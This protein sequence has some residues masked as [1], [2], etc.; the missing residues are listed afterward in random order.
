MSAAKQWSRTH[1]VYDVLMNIEK[2][3]FTTKDIAEHLPHLS[4][5]Q[6]TGAV[7]HLV[8]IGVLGKTGERKR[9]KRGRPFEV[10]YILDLSSHPKFSRARYGVKQ[11]N[12][13]P[14][15]TSKTPSPA[16][17]DELKQ[18][19]NRLSNQLLELAA[20]IESLSLSDVSDVEIAREYH[21]R[22]K[23]HADH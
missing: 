22:K 17:K 20:E 3:K 9:I 15:K 4:H 10:Y 16:R 13:G 2:T 11:R 12:R 7:A 1:D 5:R 6:I 23:Q 21:K 18:K 19:L 8:K 14:H